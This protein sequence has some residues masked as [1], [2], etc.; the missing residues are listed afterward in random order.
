MADLRVKST[1]SFAISVDIDPSLF[2]KMLKGEREWSDSAIR[3]I[4]DKYG[5]N[6]QWLIDGTGEKMKV[7]G[8]PVAKELG[9]DWQAKYISSLEKYN[10]LLESK[11]DELVDKMK[12]LQASLDQQSKMLQSLAVMQ[13]A[14]RLV[15]FEALS[16][17]EKKKDYQEVWATW[18]KKVVEVL[19][20]MSGQDNVAGVARS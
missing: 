19:K 8:R 14:E 18:D 20:E 11:N 5:L 4:S 12:D 2:A 15:I 17:L 10:Q 16:R 3:T 6:D 13:K 7:G 1:R 9:S